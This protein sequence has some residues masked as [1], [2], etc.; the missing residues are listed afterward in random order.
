MVYFYVQVCDILNRAD[1]T[2]LMAVRPED[3]DDTKHI[4][5][6]DD[7]ML[8]ELV[9]RAASS[10]GGDNNLIKGMLPFNNYVVH[11]FTCGS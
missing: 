11:A 2:G 10:T 9:E 6:T 7:E 1:E 4:I 3:F 5:I 8:D